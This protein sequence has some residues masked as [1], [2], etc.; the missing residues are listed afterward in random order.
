[1]VKTPALATW[2][3]CS[4]STASEGPPAGSTP[5]QHDQH[6]EEDE[7]RRPCSGQ[8]EPREREA[9]GCASCVRH[10]QQHRWPE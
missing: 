1:M 4:R 9:A 5:E 6:D 2:C 10:E 8:Q 7:G 3:A